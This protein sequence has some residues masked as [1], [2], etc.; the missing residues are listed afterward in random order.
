MV[1]IDGLE[2]VKKI[3]VPK[4]KYSFEKTDKFDLVSQVIFDEKFGIIICFYAGYFKMYNPMDFKETWH[5]QDS[6]TEEVN[7]PMSISAA[8]IS[9]ELGRLV[10]GGV[11]GQVKAFDI[12]SRAIM[13]ENQD[14]HSSEILTMVFY[15]AQSQ[16]IT[17]SKDR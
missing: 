11:G 15:D 12:I 16:L 10:I 1:K 14:V 3:T 4:K 17:C 13:M 5:H 9:S 7:N 8:A 6:I 2:L